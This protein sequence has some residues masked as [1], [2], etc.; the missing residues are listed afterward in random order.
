M[1]GLEINKIQ[2]PSSQESEK[3]NS[4]P[5][6][7]SQNEKQHYYTEQGI[8]KGFVAFLDIVGFKN[9]IIRDL[10]FENAI[11]KLR[12][13]S[14]KDSKIESQFNHED[15]EKNDKPIRIVRFSDTIFIFTRGATQEDLCNL[16]HT[17]SQLMAISVKEEILLKGAI[18]YGAVLCNEEDQLYV[19]KPIIDAYELEQDLNYLGLTLHHTTEKKLNEFKSLCN[20]PGRTEEFILTE[21]TPFKSGKVV[22]KNVNWPLIMNL[23]QNGSH[24][25]KKYIEKLRHSSSG[26]KHRQVIDNTLNFF[27]QKVTIAFFIVYSSLYQSGL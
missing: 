17:S 13:I 18:A 20:K 11:A 2:E 21:E 16:L 14:E 7:K 9:L 23:S 3:K 19:G 15:F 26:G 24:N 22:H 1:S 6:D 12:R 27:F 8:S 4:G 10:G 5:G 25:F